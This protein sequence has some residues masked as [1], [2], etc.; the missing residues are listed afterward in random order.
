MALA[1]RLVKIVGMRTLVVDRDPRL[2]DM[3]V[4]ELTRYGYEMLT[5][6]TGR[7]A[8]ELVAERVPQ[9]VLIE[10]DLP[11]IDGLAV[12]RCLRRLESRVPILMFAPAGP[13]EE[14][15]DA[16]DAGADDFM[17]KPL[18][19]QE[20]RARVRALTRRAYPGNDPGPLQFA[21]IRLDTGY[22]GV[23]VGA[24]FTQLTRMEYRL[25]ELFI[26]NSDR[27][28]P[29]SYIY[30]C[31]WGYDVTDTAKLRVYVGYLRRKLGQLGA[32]QL[33]HAVPGRGYIMREP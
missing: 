33:I 1:P 17:V 25:L 22:Y 29:R 14:R 28:L 27:L 13:L 7:A 16:L 19:M 18:D 9:A 24:R 30:E 11:D 32:R 15:I 31:V 12:C 6:V 26:R 8:I 5:C 2:T 3:L 10:R 21:E 20:L 23:R 4:R